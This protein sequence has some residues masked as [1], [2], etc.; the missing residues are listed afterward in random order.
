[1]IQQSGKDAGVVFTCPFALQLSLDA[2]C[3]SLDFLA[4]YPKVDGQLNTHTL[5]F[6]FNT[7]LIKS[8]IAAIF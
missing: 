5:L 3:V 6:V 7:R 2:C 1:L 8:K 4:H